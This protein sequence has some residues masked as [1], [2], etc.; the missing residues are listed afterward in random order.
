M[1]DNGIRGVA[2]IVKLLS[3]ALETFHTIP[4]GKEETPTLIRATN[5]SAADTTVTVTVG[6][7]RL[8]FNWPVKVGEAVNIL[9]PDFGVLPPGT[10]FQAR[11]GT[12]NAIEI[13]MFRSQ[14]DL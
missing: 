14:R 9:G 5:V 11:G 4:V 6:G 10:V 2:P 1:A 12:V 8:A 7:G 13:T 3:A